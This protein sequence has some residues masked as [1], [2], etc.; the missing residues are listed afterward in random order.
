MRIAF[1]LST[2]GGSPLQAGLCRGLQ[3]LGHW[4]EDYRPRGGY[5][6]IIA[7]QQSAHAPN[8]TWRAFPNEPT[9]IAFVDTAEFGYFTRLPDRARRYAT[10]FTEDAINHDTKNRAEQIRLRDWLDGRSFPYFLREMHKQIDYPSSYHPIDYPLY[11]LS[12]CDERPNREEY[13]RR[14][15]ELFCW[16]GISH[17]WRAHIT[18]ALRNAHRKAEIGDRWNDSNM[19]QGQYFERMRAAKCTVSYDGYG[20][21]S[22]RMTEALCRTVLLQGPLAIRTRAPLIDGETCVAY[23]VQ[24]DGEE[25]CGTDI[26]ERLRWTLENPEEAYAIYERG[27]DHVHTHLTERATAAYLLE[28]VERHDYSQPTPL[29]V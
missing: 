4:V 14:E 11:H 3:A 18:E 10:S 12:V 23:S 16:W 22:F 27:F 6:L 20:S 25:F 8:Y 9:P 17:P 19:A 29:T 26:A 2:L 28:T 13:L 5:D 21:G 7:F 15:L 1:F 24:S